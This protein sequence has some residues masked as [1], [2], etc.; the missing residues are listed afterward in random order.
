[1]MKRSRSLLVFGVA[2]LGTLVVGLSG[3]ISHA[4]AQGEDGWVNA[5][6]EVDENPDDIT[7]QEIQD[8]GSEPPP[9]DETPE[10]AERETNCTDGIDNDN[11]SIADCGDSDCW[12]E[13]ICEAG[14]TEERTEET[15]SDWVD[16]D[17]DG[18]VD[19]DDDDCTVDTLNVCQGSD[20]RRRV[21][22]GDGNRSGSLPSVAPGD[23]LDSL[24]GTDGDR[25]GEGNDMLCTDGIDN[26]Q[27]GR[28]DCEDYECRFNSTIRACQGAPGIRFS[29]VAGVGASADVQ[30]LADGADPAQ[31][32][33]VS[34]TRIQLR[35]LG[36]IPFI[37]NSFFLINSRIERSP[38]I[39]FALF[40]VPVTEQ[41]HYVALNSGAGNLSS[42]PIISSAK[43][44][45]L[46]RPFYLYNAF[47]QGN[48]AAF[49]FGGPLTTNGVLRFRTFIAGGAGEFNGNVGG[50]FFRTDEQNFAYAAGGQLLINAIGFWDRLDSPFLYNTVPLTLAF[51]VG[52]MFSQRPREQFPAVNVL[53]V[54]RWNRFILQAESYVKRELAFGAWQVSWN[55]VGGVL[56]VPEH[57]FLAA[58]VGSFFSTDFDNTV[59]FDSLFRRPLDELQWRVALHWFWYREIGILSAL[60][61]ETHNEANPDRPEDP[62][63]ERQ[64]RLEAQ[65]RF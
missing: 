47:E 34:F 50:R 64:V 15:C 29:V 23:T 12:E 54:L 2:S 9:P 16:N 49:E 38:R 31:A 3:P 43:L 17:G 58:D 6:E 36:P 21:I 26:D 56:L 20:Q 51:A 45:L 22:A 30:A 46:D 33:D 39:T 11:D 48:G 1:M 44:P 14:T 62:T 4:S 63:T 10:P 55:V 40:Q 28:T 24:I 57:L 42:G 8:D 65:F 27:D 18:Q 32:F 13:P 7:G 19:C 41:G 37:P 59:A 25:I 5:D 61:A 60:Y 52:G 53:S 35:A